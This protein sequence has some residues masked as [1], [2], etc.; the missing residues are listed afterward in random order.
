[1]TGGTCLKFRQA[2]AAADDRQ[3][4]ADRASNLRKSVDKCAEILFRS[5]R[6]YDTDHQCRALQRFRSGCVRG[7][8]LFRIDAVVAEVDFRG[9]C[10]V[11][12]DEI[13][14][15]G[16]AVH[17]DA[18]DQPVGDSKESAGE[19]WCELAMRPHA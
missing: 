4:Q 17:N 9:V 6:A 14:A 11:R 10:L 18:V 1:M 16:I 7:G 12:L 13:A 15:D 5:K 8:K 3:L 19:T 2:R